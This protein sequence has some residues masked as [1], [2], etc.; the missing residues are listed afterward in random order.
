MV[1]GADGNMEP[2][3]RLD[4]AVEMLC[5]SDRSIVLE[6][7]EKECSEAMIKIGVD[8]SWVAADYDNIDELLMGKLGVAPF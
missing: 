1:I 6:K 3:K 2:W 8:P 4:K 5:C 7:M